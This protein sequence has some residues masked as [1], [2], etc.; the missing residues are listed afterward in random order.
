M[1]HDNDIRNIMITGEAKKI[2]LRGAKRFREDESTIWYRKHGG[3]TRAF[4]DFAKTHP[5]DVKYFAR[6]GSHA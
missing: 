4:D 5:A 2:L 6:V 1:K 3:Y